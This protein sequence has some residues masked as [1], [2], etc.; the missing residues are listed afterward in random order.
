MKGG[1]GRKMDIWRHKEEIVVVLL[2]MNE[3]T[4]K[5][6]VLEITKKGQKE[7]SMRHGNTYGLVD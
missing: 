1:L 7:E 6:L 2:R 3:R 5:T 4:C